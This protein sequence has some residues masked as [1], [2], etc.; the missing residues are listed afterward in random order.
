VKDRTSESDRA[1]PP[2]ALGVKK[3]DV[4]N[5]DTQQ[6][7]EIVS[8]LPRFFSL[9]KDYFTSKNALL[10]TAGACRIGQL[11]A[12]FRGCNNWFYQGN[13]SLLI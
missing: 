13:I 11:T 9:L 8:A 10:K 12:L 6:D 7:V 5:A 3:Q 4:L 1:A 2:C